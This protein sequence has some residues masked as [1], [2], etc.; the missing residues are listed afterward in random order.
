MLAWIIRL[1]VF[2]VI[3]FAIFYKSW[4]LHPRTYKLSPSKIAFRIPEKL[5]SEPRGPGTTGG[6][7]CFRKIDNISRK[8]V[9]Y[10][11]WKRWLTAVWNHSR[12]S[13][14]WTT[15]TRSQL[16]CRW[17]TVNLRRVASNVSAWKQD[18]HFTKQ[19][20]SLRHPM[21]LHFALLKRKSH[22]I[23]ET[24]VKPC[25]LYC[26]K[27]VLDDRAC[28]PLKHVSLSNDSIKIFTINS[29]IEMLVK[30]KQSQKSHYTLNWALY[31][32]AWCDMM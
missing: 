21:W 13:S 11:T 8:G 9:L 28:N 32:S 16:A 22:N 31:F 23:A 29:R 1:D 6:N 15:L 20:F 26:V 7:H 17:S 18:V 25:L 2:W 19:V 24:L 4:F 27:M 3:A 5:V 10:S 12:S 14:I 30:W